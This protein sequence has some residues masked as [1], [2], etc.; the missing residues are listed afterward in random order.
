MQRRKLL[1]TIGVGAVTMGP[2]VSATRSS[3]ES[4][5]EEHWKKSIEIRSEKGREA[6]EDF[7]DDNGFRTGSKKF[8]NSVNLGSDEKKEGGDLN[9]HSIQDPQSGGI[10]V[11]LFG[12]ENPRASHMFVGV[13]VDYE[14]KAECWR[15][16]WWGRSHGE[17]PKDAIGIAWNSYQNEYFDLARGGGSRAMTE[18]LNTEWYEDL[19]DPS[20]GRTVFRAD[21]SNSYY[22]WED[23]LPDC[24]LGNRNEYEKEEVR[25]A[26]CSL[27]LEPKGDFEPEERVVRAAYTH[28]HGDLSISP[29]LGWSS[30]GPVVSFSPSYRVNE[31]TITT[32]D[33]GT[34]I[35]ISQADLT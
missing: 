13:Q 12:G 20:Q 8:K 24:N 4:K 2:T 32:S 22:D 1:Q 15:Y 28:S 19:H 31:D 33:D 7:L 30:T 10:S 25:G 17:N 21:D 23:D 34:D 18:G 11:E 16:R 6:A 9:I 14:F 27:A 3:G 26:V 35:E 5:S 29:S